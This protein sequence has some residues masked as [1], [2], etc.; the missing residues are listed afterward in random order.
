MNSNGFFGIF[1]GSGK[2]TIDFLLLGHNDISKTM[3]ND[4]IPSDFKI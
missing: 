3:S 2:S 4:L 1:D